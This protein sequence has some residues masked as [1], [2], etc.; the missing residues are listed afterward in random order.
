MRFAAHGQVG[1]IVGVDQAYYRVHGA[2]MHLQHFG[3]CLQ[4]LEQRREAF[5]VLFEN[6]G[7][8]VPERAELRASA[9]RA[10]ACVAL[11]ELSRALDRGERASPDERALLDFAEQIPPVD[12]L[13]PDYLRAW[14]GWRLRTLLGPGLSSRVSV[15]PHPAALTPSR[16]AACRRRQG[17][18]LPA[19]SFHRSGPVSGVRRPVQSTPARPALPPEDSG[20]PFPSCPCGSRPRASRPRCSPPSAR[21]STPRASRTAPRSPPSRPSSPATLGVR[22][23]VALNSGTSALHAALLC[24]GVGPGDEVVTV[25]HTWISTVWAISYVGAKPVFVDVDPA[26]SGMDP[27]QVERAL[28]AA[29]PRDPAGAP[30]RTAGGPRAHPGARP[31]PR[32]PGHRGLRAGAGRALS[33]PA[34]GHAGTGQ[35][36]QLLPGEE[37]RRVRRGRR[38]DHRRAAARGPGAAPARSR[39]GRPAQPRGAGLQLAHGRDPGRGAVG[40][41]AAPRRLERAPGRARRALPGRTGGHTGTHPAGDARLVR[42]HL[43]R[44]RRLPRSARRLAGRPSRRAACRP[45]STTRGRCTCSPP[46]R[47]WGSDRGTLP[48]SERLADTELSLPLFPELTDAQADEVV[49][50]T[51]DACEEL[52]GRQRAG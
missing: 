32:D 3:S 51:I 42:A 2:N 50:A 4:D 31:P 37:P 39:A 12:R 27:A 29:H 19:S 38:A 22:E 25:A 11:Q 48:V 5:E 33:R 26:T 47:T 17:P 1:E 13:A 30:L 10:L 46:T 24:A 6:H 23:V 35:R 15:A 52:A 28:T 49:A 41:A 40:Q 34:G 16:G 44:L 7:D 18:H 21:C 20:C 43:A 36:H 8:R 9:R 14:G 45:G